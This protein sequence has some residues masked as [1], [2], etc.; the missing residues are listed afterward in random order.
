MTLP[1]SVVEEKLD[2]T[3]G[4]VVVGMMP[5][6]R[7]PE[8]EAVDPAVALA[9]LT[10]AGSEAPDGTPVAV[11]AEAPVLLQLLQGEVVVFLEN[12]DDADPDG[13]LLGGPK[14][15]V[16]LPF[17]VDDTRLSVPVTL[18]CTWVVVE[19][20]DWLVVLQRLVVPGEAVPDTLVKDVVFPK[21]GL[22]VLRTAVDEFEAVVV[23]MT[24]MLCHEPD[25]SPY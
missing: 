25:I 8:G 2:P 18:L 17:V 12:V 23:L 3:F 6:M 9:L 4:K 14:V 10:K 13:M 19:V 20:T 16:L 5:L 15:T 7:L 11:I 24:L 22:V 21:L 1:P